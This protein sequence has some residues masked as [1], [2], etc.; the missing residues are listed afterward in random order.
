MTEGEEERTN[1]L[2]LWTPVIY[3]IAETSSLRRPRFKATQ[4]KKLYTRNLLSARSDSLP[5]RRTKVSA[6]SPLVRATA[7][8]A[9]SIDETV[10]S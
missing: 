6:S 4:L 1:A 3:F 10:N 8:N 7:P 2:C 5:L 9:V